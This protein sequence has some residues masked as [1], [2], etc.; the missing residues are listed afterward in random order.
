MANPRRA[1]T[2][3]AKPEVD[4]SK[5]RYELTEAA[6]IGDVLHQEGAEIEFDGIPG[7]HMIPL[8]EAAEQQCE[9]YDA[10]MTPHDPIHALTMVGDGATVLKSVHNQG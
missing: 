2:R 6:Y 3:Q 10:A 8:N 5:P 4:E 1:S 9:K 7:P